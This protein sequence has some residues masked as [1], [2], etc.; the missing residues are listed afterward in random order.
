MSTF[1]GNAITNEEIREYILSDR[2]DERM[3]NYIR[4]LLLDSNGGEI[5]HIFEE[6][7]PTAMNQTMRLS[8]P[9]TQ[10][11]IYRLAIQDAITNNFPILEYDIPNEDLITILR[12][13]Y[14]NITVDID[15]PDA[16]PFLRERAQRIMNIID[17]LGLGMEIYFRR[18][19]FGIRR[20]ST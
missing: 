9:I 14:N 16:D 13:E 10:L 11:P 8:P 1:N 15:D 6:I 17:D 19:R 20:Q 4:S 2:E 18:D 7:T 12:D 5:V 3:D